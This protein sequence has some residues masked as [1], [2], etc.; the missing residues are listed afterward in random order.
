MGIKCLYHYDYIMYK[1]EDLVRIAKREKNKKRSYLFVNPLQGKHIPANPAKVDDLC[2]CLADAID[3]DYFGKT[4]LVI[5][6]A[7][8][9]TGIAAAVCKHLNNIIYFEHTTRE[10][11]ENNKYIYFTESHSHAKDQL[12]DQQGLEEAVMSVNAIILIDDEITT[13][14]TVCKLIDQIKMNYG[15]KGEFVIASFVNSMTDERIEELKKQGIECRYVIKI[16]HE[17]KAELAE[18]VDELHNSD[19]AYQ[20][21][22]ELTVPFPVRLKFNPRKTVVWENYEADMQDASKVII[23]SCNLNHND[24]VCIIGTEEFMYL[25][26]CLGNEMI[27]NGLVNDVKVHSTTRSPIVPSS[28]TG[29]PLKARFKLTSLYDETRVTY[30]YNLSKYDKVIVVT[31]GSCEDEGIKS[32]LSAIRSVGNKMVYVY[33]CEYEEQF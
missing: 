29:Y 15:Y 33:G 2:K 9:A 6:F 25:T 21:I 30:L 20:P 8:T 18:R 26:V 10:Y 13:G 17:Y 28:Q 12:L 32:L 31:D 14:N 1:I 24:S 19:S 4:K 7:E 22:T 16:P 23:D 27:K 3:Q 5:G 11:G